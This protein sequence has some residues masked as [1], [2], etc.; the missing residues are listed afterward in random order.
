M[1]WT[2]RLGR[3]AAGIGDAISGGAQ[4]LYAPV[5]MVADIAF[6]PLTDDP[7]FDSLLDKIRSRASVRFG[8]VGQGF[9]RIGGGLD[10]AMFGVDEAFAAPLAR[11]SEAYMWMWSNV[12]SQPAATTSIQFQKALGLGAQGAQPGALLSGEEWGSAYH[13]AEHVSPGQANAAGWGSAIAM[14]IPGQ[15]GVEKYDLSTGDGIRRAVGD[16]PAGSQISGA[17][18]FYANVFFDPTVAIGKGAAA[19]RAA[20]TFTNQ[21]TIDATLANNRTDRFLGQLFQRGTPD[22]RAAWLSRNKAIAD[23]RNPETPKLIWLLAHAE[24]PEDARMILRTAMLRDPLAERALRVRSADSAAQLDYLVDTKIPLMEK[25][26]AGETNTFQVAWGKKTTADLRAE[27]EAAKPVV[28]RNQMLADVAGTLERKPA[29]GLRQTIGDH[30]SWDTWQPSPYNVPIRVVKAASTIR[31]GVVNYHDSTSWIN[32]Q[33]FLEQSGVDRDSRGR[34]MLEWAQATDRGINEAGMRTVLEKAESAATTA[35]AVRAGVSRETADLIL[36]HGQVRRSEVFARLSDPMYSTVTRDGQRID[37]ILDDK[38]VLRVPIDVSQNENYHA[39]LDLTD[40]DRVLRRY[41]PELKGREA[42]LEVVLDA[43]RRRKPLPQFLAG[44][45]EVGQAFNNVW[46]PAQLLRLGYTVRN[47]TDESLRTIA[48]H[49]VISYLPMVGRALKGRHVENVADRTEKAIARLEQKASVGRATDVE[50]GVL[51]RLKEAQTEVDRLFGGTVQLGRYEVEDLYGGEGAAALRSLI[52]ARDHLRQLTTDQ[53]TLI[54]RMRTAASDW[55]EKAPLDDGYKDAWLRAVNDQILSGPVFRKVLEGQTDEQ[56]VRWLRTSEGR[57][58]RRRMGLRGGNPNLWAQEA[59]MHVEHLLPTPELRAVAAG[60]KR[61]KFSDLER[62]VPEATLRP[63]VHAE[64]LKIASGASIPMRFLRSSVDRAMD[65]LG[66]APN[67]VLVRHPFAELSYRAKM[68]ELL[69]A[70]DPGGKGILDEAEL[71][72]MQDHSRAYAL[73]QTRETMYEL[74]EQPNIARSVRFL[75]PFYGA[76]HDMMKTWGQLFVEDPS[77]IGRGLQLWNMPDKA[78]WVKEN[79]YGDQ[80]LV[81]PVPEWAR[82]HIPGAKHLGAMGFTK[83]SILPMTSGQNPMIPGAG[84]MVAIPAAAFARDRPDVADSI[85][86]ILPFGPGDDA[87]DQFIPAWAK[88]LRSSTSEDEAFTRT[89][90]RIFS[91]LVYER[92]T[93]RNQMSDAEL[94]DEAKRRAKS[95]FH[96]RTFVNLTFPA[97][98]Q[99]QSPYQFYIDRAKEYQDKW[100]ADGGPDGQ[101]WESM[102]I[103]DFGEEYWPFTLAMSKAAVSVAPTKE[104]FHAYRQMKDLIGRYPEYS[105]LFVGDDVGDGKFSRAVYEW[106]F[107][108]GAGTGSTERMRKPLDPQ[109]ALLEINRSQGWEK[110]IAASRWL[111]GQMKARGVASLSDP[112]AADLAQLKTA[113]RL[114]LQQK[115]PDWYADYTTYD[116]EKAANVMAA[117]KATMDDPRLRDAAGWAS[118]REYAAKRD[119]FLAVLRARDQAGGSLN[120]QAEQNADLRFMWEAY[121][122]QLRSTDLAFASIQARWL[123]NDTLQRGV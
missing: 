70:Y 18:D 85:K 54:N 35:A 90:T 15:Q 106:Q 117:V 30:V 20:R 23:S 123:D 22:S 13:E 37:S 3:A 9:G 27:A 33:R 53:G 40:L 46:K 119:A 10:Q 87:L 110:W 5:G 68:R 7:E 71:R 121:V 81:L 92:N 38:S 32:V 84:Y 88:R 44:L 97:I 76:W 89:W 49:G 79:E 39:L 98:P 64:Q 120:L 47:I 14:L 62:A 61:M 50:L 82:K 103:R 113:V 1:G 2:D 12:V 118:L 78:G 99:Y 63:T 105:G 101:S 102:F 31:P 4:A 93:G 17:M 28:T 96:L 42:D 11:A 74:T 108:T 66:A 34:L 60:R 6:M 112:R 94:I 26:L 104:G 111:D 43:I 52:S 56:I 59:R 72:R 67:D 57:Q 65:A 8:D 25:V 114:A 77:R 122:A 24:D 45:E 16:L 58:I 115:F 36:K 109:A 80:V 95:F 73:R 21:A 19:L 86:F 75:V 51:E 55:V 100:G 107:R 116:T 83:A 48:V 91:D 29:V 41:A 69:H